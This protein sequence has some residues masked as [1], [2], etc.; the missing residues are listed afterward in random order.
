MLDMF[1]AP[2][3]APSA[4]ELSGVFRRFRPLAPFISMWAGGD[5]DEAV[6]N[7]LSD[8]PV[9][10]RALAVVLMREVLPLLDGLTETV[11]AAHLQA[12]IDSVLGTA[13]EGNC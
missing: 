4:R 8:D 1:S 11:A 13:V 2:A 12:A 9:V 7:V 3:P 5:M 6:G 10:R